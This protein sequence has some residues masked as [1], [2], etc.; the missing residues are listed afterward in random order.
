MAIITRLTVLE[1]HAQPWNARNHV[2][3]VGRCDRRLSKIP[4]QALQTKDIVG[5]GYIR[6]DAPTLSKKLSVLCA[7][8]FKKSLLLV[9]YSRNISCCM[10]ELMIL[11]L[12]INYHVKIMH[13]SG[14]HACDLEIGFCSSHEV[15]SA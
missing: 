6:P 13:C 11:K 10:C 1:L 8:L 12:N 4:L 5:H 2:P 9:F 14:Q 15:E 7:W 3:Y